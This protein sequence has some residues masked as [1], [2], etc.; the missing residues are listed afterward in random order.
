[1]NLQDKSKNSIL[2]IILASSLPPQFVNQ[3]LDDILK[4]KRKDLQPDLVNEAGEIALQLSIQKQ[5]DSVILTTSFV[6]S[7]ILGLT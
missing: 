1:M 4:A 2:H 6:F 7:M 5:T 3:H